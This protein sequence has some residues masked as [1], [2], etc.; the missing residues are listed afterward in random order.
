MS[1]VI[2]SALFFYKGRD[3]KNGKI[4]AGPVWDYDLAFRNAEYCDGSRT[5]GWAYDFNNI[6][7]TDGAGL[8][9]FWWKKLL[10]DSL[11][12]S[13]L[14]C[15]WKEV[16]ATSLSQNRINTLIDSIVILTGEAQQ[17]HFQR[18][19]ILGQYV[20]P[21]PQPIPVSYDGEISTLK[22]WI[23]ERLQWVDAN[24][25]NAGTCADFPPEVRES[26]IISI[27][28]NPLQGNGTAT[29][30]SRI[31]QPVS[32]RVFDITGRNVYSAEHSLAA[33]F[34][35]VSFPSI[36]WSKGVYLARFA[37]G[38]EKIVRKIVVQ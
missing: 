26:V 23:T 16:R 7:P 9:P 36:G 5:Q 22:T 10:Q 21:N 37:T 28:P 14:R 20:W 33:G 3:S 17:R 19:P 32:V 27:Y 1:M 38:T 8:I 18:W 29:V 12:A 31:A 13:D 11:F 24:I 25:A 4:V 35:S 2:G 15:R 6:C 30:Q 34:N